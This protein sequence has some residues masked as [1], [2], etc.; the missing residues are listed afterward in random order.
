MDGAIARHQDHQDAPVA[1]RNQFD[2]IQFAHRRR[3]RGGDADIAGELRQDMAAT[4]HPRRGGGRL[5][6][7]DAQA[8]GVGGRHASGIERLHVI[9]KRFFGRHTAGGS[10]RLREV[11]GIRQ[12]AHHVPDG[13]R[14]Q[15]V[16]CGVAQ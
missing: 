4:F 7:L 12:A 6:Q 14:A 10:M 8:G 2:L 5:Q 13:S 11:A 15:S 1:Q 3:Q 9:A 16:D